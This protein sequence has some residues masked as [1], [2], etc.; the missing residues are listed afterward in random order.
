[1][2]MAFMLGGTMTAKVGKFP[3]QMRNDECEQKYKRC[4]IK[5]TWDTKLKKHFV[6]VYGESQII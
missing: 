3:V 4:L 1:M 6:P 5:E 2:R